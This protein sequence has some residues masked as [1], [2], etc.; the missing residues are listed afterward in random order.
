[1]P[2]S[3][4]QEEAVACIKASDEGRFV[5]KACP[6]SGK[7]YTIAHLLTQELEDWNSE[8]KGIA[9]LSFTNKASEEVLSKFE[10]NQAANKLQAP[11]YV[12]TFDK[13]FNQN[14]FLPFARNCLSL[15]KEPTLVGEPF[16]HWKGLRLKWSGLLFE[17]IDYKLDG[18]LIDPPLY[19]AGI[20][21]AL[22]VRYK[23]EILQMKRTV[24]SRGFFTQRDALFFAK[25]ILS[26]RPDIG[27]LLANRY[28]YIIIDEAQDSSDITMALVDIL[29]GYGVK[30]VVVVGDPDQ[31]IYEWNNAR[32]GLFWEKWEDPN[33]TKIELNESYRSSDPICSF[34]S[35]FSRVTEFSPADLNES[36]DFSIKPVIEGVNISGYELNPPGVLE[37]VAEIK[38][39][40]LDEC[41]SNGI[42][43]NK[44]NI[45]ILCRSTADLHIIRGIES[46]AVSVDWSKC[47]KLFTVELCTA[48]YLF[49]IAKHDL[50]YKHWLKYKIHQDTDVSFASSD[51]LNNFE[52]TNGGRRVLFKKCMEELNDLP[53]TDSD[54]LRNWVLINIPSETKYNLLPEIDFTTAF[55]RHNDDDDNTQP[56]YST[57]HGIKGATFD[58]VLLFLKK[59]GASGVYYKTYVNS[60]SASLKDA[61]SEEMRIA[62][63]AMTRPRK[64]LTVAVPEDDLLVWRTKFAELIV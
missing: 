31:A 8:R 41:V 27:I 43:I 48:K 13:F 1:M 54:N 47:E 33:W 46:S 35:A 24:N 5:I 57:I 51:E 6:G 64:L 37:A 30:K 20:N 25:H 2:L 14:V 28:P 4:K 12:G 62:Y 63:V 52:D 61:N 42:E 55:F 36:K 39:S 38:R 58:A 15:S 56:L 11:H 44:S 32:P 9:V 10:G 45:A 22:Y 29:I 59:K 60:A 21:A 17:H 49:E 16:G 50:A 7:T 53:S 34:A 18:T 19:R 26:S 40:F 3:N 23:T